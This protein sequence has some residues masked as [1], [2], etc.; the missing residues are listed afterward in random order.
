ME[1]YPN[2][3]PEF[4]DQAEQTPFN[5]D[6]MINEEIIELGRALSFT[7][8]AL[9]ENSEEI[10]QLDK[11][12]EK[13]Q[14]AVRKLPATDLERAQQLLASQLNSQ[15]E[16]DLT[17]A[18]EWANGFHDYDYQLARDTL[19]RLYVD[20][21]FHVGLVRDTARRVIDQLFD[22]RLTPEQVADYKAK[23]AKYHD[24]RRAD[25]HAQP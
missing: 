8:D 2:L 16:H 9:D 23:I 25:V 21:T 24:E 6:A 11:I 19:V 7:A 12:W 3:T 20:E 4:E 10:A 5:I 14:A 18:A 22:T 13:L 17:A 1:K 15:N